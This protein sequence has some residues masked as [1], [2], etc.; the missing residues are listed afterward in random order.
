MYT[1]TCI[2]L[3]ILLSI[4]ESLY[5]A[6]GWERRA[7]GLVRPAVHDY[8]QK[9]AMFCIPG[10]GNRGLS[11]R[12]SLVNPASMTDCNH[13]HDHFQIPDIKQDTV[14]ADAIAPETGVLSLQRLSKMAGILASLFQT[15]STSPGIRVEI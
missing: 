15:V 9:A 11:A 4:P 3:S 7:R 12:L 1:Q 14:S 5:R 2:Y 10:A 8:K 6:R 13:Q